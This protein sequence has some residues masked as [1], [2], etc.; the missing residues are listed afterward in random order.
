[1]AKD[2]PKDSGQDYEWQDVSQS[3]G[4]TQPSARGL[5]LEHDILGLKLIRADAQVFELFYKGG[6]AFFM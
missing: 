1:L 2:K 5:D 3:G 6:A 4:Y